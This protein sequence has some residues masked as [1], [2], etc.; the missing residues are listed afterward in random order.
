M[1]GGKLRIEC[2]RVIKAI[3]FQPLGLHGGDTQIVVIGAQMD[4]V[5][6][7]RRQLAAQCGF[8]GS[9]PA[10]NQQGDLVLLGLLEMAA[11]KAVKYVSA[12]IERRKLLPGRFMHRQMIS[13]V[14]LTPTL[15]DHRHG[16]PTLNV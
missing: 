10:C 15:V 12:F 11:N 3:W 9:R 8:A 2:P 13:A 6:T 16:Y 5:R 4:P 7:F 1:T 14:D